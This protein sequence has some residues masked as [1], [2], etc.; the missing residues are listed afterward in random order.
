[1]ARAQWTPEQKEAALLSLHDGATLNQVH[2][3]TGIPVGTL[4]S[5][6][7]RQGVA[8]REAMKQELSAADPEGHAERAAA[9]AERIERM[10][11][12]RA[13]WEEVQDED[14]KQLA[15]RTL[16]EIHQI[17]DRINT[18]TVYKHVKTVGMG[19]GRQEV[20]VVDVYL[21]LPNAQDTK[22]L[23]TSA[24]I[25]VD[26]LQLLTGQ[27]TER[28]E[29]LQPDSLDLDAAYAELVA[30]AKAGELH[31]DKAADQ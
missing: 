6:K 5:W 11:A 25:L 15:G 31:P 17:L 1:M 21:D 28:S 9:A 13:R 24:A 22:A 27:A 30:K 16:L 12:A 10:A 20:E 14:R 26:K 18:P 2:A 7:R 23:V 8:E 19:E 3:D 4:S 29:H